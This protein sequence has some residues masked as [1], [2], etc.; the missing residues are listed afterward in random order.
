MIKFVY[1]F[2]GMYIINFMCNSEFEFWK[3]HIKCII[4]KI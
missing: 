1:E 2:C 3:K 4:N